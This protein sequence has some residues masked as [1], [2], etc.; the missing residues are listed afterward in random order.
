[1][2]PSTPLVLACTLVLPALIFSAR[3]QEGLEPIP[4]KEV[5]ELRNEAAAPH[6]EAEIDTRSFKPASGS[7]LHREQAPRDSV[8]LHQ[9][10]Q[11]K[12]EKPRQNDVLQFNFLY[13]II[14]RYKFSDIIE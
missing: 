1:M 13:Y 5:R 12:A 4:G 3:A 2:K 14:Q 6:T 11:R 10:P 9:P 8:M 7:F